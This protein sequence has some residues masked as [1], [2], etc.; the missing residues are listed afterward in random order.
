M[1]ALGGFTPGLAASGV[2]DEIAAPHV[3]CIGTTGG[4]ILAMMGRAGLGHSGRPPVFGPGLAIAC[5]LSPAAAL[6]RALGSFA[7]IALYWN[8]AIAAGVLRCVAFGSFASCLR[9]PLTIPRGP[10]GP[11]SST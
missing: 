2:F 3:I 8:A 6:L 1:L 9:T 10:K 11:I 7:E 4:M 5:A